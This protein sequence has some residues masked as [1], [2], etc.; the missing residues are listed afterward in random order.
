MVQDTEYWSNST[1]KFLFGHSYGSLSC[2][3]SV[4][5]GETITLINDGI[6]LC[7]CLGGFSK[8][9]RWIV[10]GQLTE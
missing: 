6:R 10:I 5:V 9:L 4:K 1:S 8:S 2:L 7:T 3:S